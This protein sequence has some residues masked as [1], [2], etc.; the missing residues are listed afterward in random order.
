MF[1]VYNYDSTSGKVKMERFV[2]LGSVNNVKDKK[3]SDIRKMLTTEKGLSFR[4]YVI[5][6]STSLYTMSADQPVLNRQ[7]SLFCNAEGVEAQES[8]S[9]SVCLENVGATGSIR[10]AIA[11]YDRTLM[12]KSGYNRKPPAQR[13]LRMKR[14]AKM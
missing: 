6:R 12:A 1:Y 2:S 5:L 4:Q 14:R 11:I 10:S 9:F 7:G 13:N 3:M 8:T